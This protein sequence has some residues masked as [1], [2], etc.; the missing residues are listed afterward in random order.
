MTT[1]EMVLLHSEGMTFQK[2]A[3]ICGVSR[4]AVHQRVS[5]YCED[6]IDKRGRQFNVAKIKYKGLY[7]HFMN[8]P[9][10]IIVESQCRAPLYLKVVGVGK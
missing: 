5:T 8:N 4:Q 9:N 6:K 7:E 10:E 3:D 2:I 1:K